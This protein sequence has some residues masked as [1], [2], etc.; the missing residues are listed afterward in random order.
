MDNLEKMFL[1]SIKDIVNNNSI[2]ILNFYRNFYHAQGES[3][4]RGIVA[5]AIN[6]ILP[7]YVKQKK[8]LKRLQNKNRTT[9]E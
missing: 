2:E 4:E 7:K 1:E 5:W 9:A 8:E 6:D 3:T